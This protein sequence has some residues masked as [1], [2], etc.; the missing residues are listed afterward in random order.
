MSSPIRNFSKLG[1]RQGTLL[2]TRV[3]LG[4]EVP[5]RQAHALLLGAARKTAEIRDVPAPYVYQRALSD[6]Y[7]EYE[8]FASIDEP[9][10][11]IPVL[12][13]LH[14]SILDEFNQHGV[15]I[16]SPH[17]LGQPQQPLVVPEERWYA[18]P[19]RKP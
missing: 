2:T 5:W 10:R 3:T 15:Q 17:Y 16:M 8:L 4:Y 14:A 12:S 7:V 6:F 9:A 11:R 1:A 13:A 19:A 18:Q